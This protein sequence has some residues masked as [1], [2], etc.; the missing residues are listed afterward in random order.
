MNTRLMKNCS[1]LSI[2]ICLKNLLHRKLIQLLAVFSMFL[3]LSQILHERVVTERQHN[4]DTTD[5]SEFYLIKERQYAD[6]RRRINEYCQTQ[7]TNFSRQGNLNMIYDQT[8]F[9][10]KLFKALWNKNFDP[11]IY[12]EEA[13]VAVCIIA[14]V[15]SSTWLDHFSL[16]KSDR[17]NHCSAMMLHA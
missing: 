15:A 14:K 10:K 1:R 8:K 13:G 2:V 6:R 5:M 3:L 9:E 7:S 4:Q 12:D 16:I 11:L 17:G